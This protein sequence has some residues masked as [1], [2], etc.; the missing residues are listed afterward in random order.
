MAPTHQYYSYK[1]DDEQLSLRHQ[2]VP[3]DNAPMLPLAE[4]SSES[5]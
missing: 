4:L 3:K 2:L 5:E 1:Y